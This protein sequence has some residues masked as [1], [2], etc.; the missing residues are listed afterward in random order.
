MRQIKNSYGFAVVEA[1][2]IVVILAIVAIAGYKVYTTK[3]STDKVNSDT[4]AVSQQTN[5]VSA[6]IPAVNKTS[7]LDR[8]SQA[9]DQYDSSTQDNSDSSLLDQQLSVF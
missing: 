6:T 9:L 4:A 8:A 3:Q 1:V 7:D 2:L 5:P